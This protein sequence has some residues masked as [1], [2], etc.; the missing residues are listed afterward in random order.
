[1]QRNAYRTSDAELNICFRLP[2]PKVRSS[3]LPLESRN[4]D[5]EIDTTLGPDRVIGE[6]SFGSVP[7]FFVDV[8]YVDTR[9]K[10]RRRTPYA[11]DPG[12]ES[13]STHAASLCLFLIQASVYWANLWFVYS[14]LS[15]DFRGGGGVSRNS[16]RDVLL[17]LISTQPYALFREPSACIDVV[18]SRATFEKPGWELDM[19]LK[20]IHIPCFH[21]LR[22]F[23]FLSACAGI[24]A[25]FGL[26]ELAS[27]PCWSHVNAVMSKASMGNRMLAVYSTGYCVA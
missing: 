14:L 24:F 18:E 5:S 17:P 7:W 6:W 25:L 11:E 21:V 1:M 27:L 16:H 23:F 20:Y 10:L 26:N 15:F 22:L 4:A 19:K 9:K 12:C 3:A 8:P 2:N 13:K